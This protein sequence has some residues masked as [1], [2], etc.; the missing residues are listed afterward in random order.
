MIDVPRRGRLA[1]ERAVQLGDAVGQ[2][3]ED[4]LAALL[5]AVVDD[6]QLDAASG[7]EDR[8][9]DRRRWP[10]ADGLVERVADDLVQPRLGAV[11]ELVTCGQIE[12]E[13]DATPGRVALGQLADGGSEPEIAQRIGLDAADDL[14][15]VDARLA[16]NDE[17]PFDD[18]L[19]LATSP[20][21]NA[22]WAA[23]SIWA[24]AETS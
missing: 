15:Q 14:A 2:R 24:I 21:A 6:P 4:R 11:T 7:R 20:A 1:R 18:G 5:T 22:W 16:R 3:V 10:A 12:L 23:S 17:R 13:H 19:P 8:D 9:G